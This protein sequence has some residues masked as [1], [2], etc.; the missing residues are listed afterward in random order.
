MPFLRKNSLNFLFDD[1]QYLKILPTFCS[2]LVYE[3]C[4]LHVYTFVICNS[5]GYFFKTT[6]TI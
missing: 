6:E 2:G 1:Y 4:P 3:T 5:Y